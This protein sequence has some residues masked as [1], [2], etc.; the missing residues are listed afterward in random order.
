MLWTVLA[1]AGLVPAP[2][3]ASLPAAA[4][5]LYRAAA[6]LRLADAA[7]AAGPT[8][9]EAARAARARATIELRRADAGLAGEAEL[10]AGPGGITLAAWRRQ[11]GEALRPGGAATN[12][13][14]LSDELPYDD[15]FVRGVPMGWY[16]PPGDDG[17][18]LA[19]HASHPDWPSRL[20]R[21]AA[22]ALAGILGLWWGRRFGSTAWPEQLTLLGCAAWAADGG[23]A[24]LLLAVVGVAARVAVFSGAVLRR[25][26]PAAESSSRADSG[27]RIQL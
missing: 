4:A 3:A 10:P 13:L 20:L 14:E 16:V 6:H 25:W 19:W 26:W 18:R 24:W 23:L 5:A 15:A 9:A 21:T 27:Q 2:D 7:R 11:L 17:P 22:V 8:A 12:M 1:P